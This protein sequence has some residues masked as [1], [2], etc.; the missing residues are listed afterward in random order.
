M[1]IYLSEHHSNLEGPAEWFL[2]C[3]SSTMSIYILVGLKYTKFQPVL[4]QL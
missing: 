4:P 3:L 1:H 2:K